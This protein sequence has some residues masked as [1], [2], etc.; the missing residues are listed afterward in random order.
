M[1]TLKNTTIDDS[2]FL[3][4]PRGTTAQRPVSPTVGMLRFNTTFGLAEVYNGS[5]WIDPGSGVLILDIGKT[6]AFPA[7]SAKQLQRV[8]GNSAGWF[9]IDVFRDGNPQLLYIDNIFDGGGYYLVLQNRVNTGGMTFL[10]YGDAVSGFQTFRNS[11]TS[12][13]Y[14]AGTPITDFN[15]FTGMRLWQAM[16]QG[17]EQSGSGGGRV[18]VMAATSPVAL[19]A[20]GSH[21]KRSIATYTGFGQDSGFEWRFLGMSQV[22]NT[23]NAP[24]FITFA[25]NNGRGLTTTDR[26]IDSHPNNCANFYDGQPYW[27]TACWSGNPWG[28]SANDGPYWTSS[29]A[30]NRVNY[31]AVYVR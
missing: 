22:S 30:G 31:L 16:T 26:D 19:N 25:M 8:I 7:R 1:A 23:D 10:P 17:P 20:T 28:F 11:A 3:Q 9:Y 18:A 24:G 13:N 12:N 4:L 14:S 6:K 29:D 5:N 2:G 21:F 27:Y 15:L